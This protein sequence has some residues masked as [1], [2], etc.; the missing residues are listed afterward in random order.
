MNSGVLIALILVFG[1]LL[2]ALIQKPKKE[3]DIIE[4]IG[5]DRDVNWNLDW[6]GGPGYDRYKLMSGRGPYY[7]GPYHNRNENPTYRHRR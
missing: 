1:L 7:T 6:R 2:F 5:S 3:I 4:I